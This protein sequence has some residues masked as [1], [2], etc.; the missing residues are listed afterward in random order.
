[1]KHNL[2]RYL[3]VVNQ[4]TVKY[5]TSCVQSN[6]KY[7]INGYMFGNLNPSMG[8]VLDAGSRVRWN[9]MCTSAESTVS[10]HDIM[11]NGHSVVDSE[12]TPL[13]SYSLSCPGYGIVD[14][15]PEEL[16]SWVISAG[17][18]LQV[19]MT[20]QFRVDPVEEEKSWAADE[21]LQRGAIA[22]IVICVVVIVFGSMLVYFSRSDANQ[23]AADTSSHSNRSDVPLT[24]VPMSD[25]RE[26]SF[27]SYS[28]E[29]TYTGGGGGDRSPYEAAKVAVQHNNGEE[30]GGGK[31][32]DSATRFSDVDVDAFSADLSDHSSH[33]L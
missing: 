16:G 25:Y 32:I 17:S 18:S 8:M 21:T 27:S 13:S 11:W 28:Y 26:S 19:G 7:S 15:V 10:T 29:N 22:G 4:H 1:M 20:A 12:G 5:T 33:V 24:R 3:N 6:I 9:V 14:M 30:A 23:K 31:G 2:L